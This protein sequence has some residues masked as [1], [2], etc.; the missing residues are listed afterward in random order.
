MALNIEA[1]AT[2]DNFFVVECASKETFKM[3]GESE[4]VRCGEA[5]GKYKLEFVQECLN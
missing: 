3:V 5:F 1:M 2:E 4:T